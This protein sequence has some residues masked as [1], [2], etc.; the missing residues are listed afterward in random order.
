MLLSSSSDISD[1]LA[2]EGSEPGF[3]SLNSVWPI[4][5][6]MVRKCESTRP[7]YEEEEFNSLLSVLNF[8]EGREKVK[9]KCKPIC[10]LL[11]ESKPSSIFNANSGNKQASFSHLNVNLS[12]HRRTFEENILS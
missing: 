8:K 3:C 5:K 1:A 4:N 7:Q 10:E 2:A 11:P 6:E 9:E 12:S